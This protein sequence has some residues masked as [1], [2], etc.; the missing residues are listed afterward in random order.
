M[1]RNAH[2]DARDR[3]FGIDELGNGIDDHSLGAGPALW[4]PFMDC[5]TDRGSSVVDL[6]DRRSDVGSAYIDADPSLRAIEGHGSIGGQQ[7]IR[8]GRHG[9]SHYF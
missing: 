3:A 8:G 2:P 4:R 9:G 1:P 7:I 5:R 6:Y